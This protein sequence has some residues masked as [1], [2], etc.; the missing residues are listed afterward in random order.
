MDIVNS[1]KKNYSD[2]YSL[3]EYMKEI[4]HLLKKSR[5]P[6]KHNKITS[7]ICPVCNQSI[8]PE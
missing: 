5:L 3:K 7:N 8:N 2:P 4:Q 1:E 6:K